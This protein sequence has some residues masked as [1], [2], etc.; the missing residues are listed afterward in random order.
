M[1]AYNAKIRQ[2]LGDGSFVENIK[3]RFTDETIRNQIQ[4]LSLW[5]AEPTVNGQYFASFVPAILDYFPNMESFMFSTNA[6]M[7]G[8]WIYEKFFL[9]LY[10]YC[11]THQR[12]LKWNLQLS[13]DGPPEFN[14]ASRHAGATRNTI[15]AAKILLDNAPEHS[16]FLSIHITTKPTL[17][18]SYMKI[19]NE[20]GLDS[21]NWYFQFFN[22]VQDEVMQHLKQDYVQLQMNGVPTVVDPGCHTVE[23]GKIFA[24]WVNNLKYVDMNK[25]NYYHGQPL[26]YQLIS[27]ID[28]VINNTIIR[29]NPLGSEWNAFSCSAS[30]N[31]ITV[32]Y[33]GD[34]YTCNR[35]CR[36]A[37][38]P[39][40]ERTKHA[41]LSGSTLNQS[42]R[43]WL[44][45]T[46]G[47]AGFHG[48]LKSRRYLFD[49]MVTVMA[50]TGQI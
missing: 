50:K 4:D 19:M 9:P 7:G 17:D 27:G 46:W 43:R 33:N 29:D 42:E 48:D 11:E 34:L 1:E 49:A 21:F 10:E 37:A 18:V 2:A 47:S 35:L 39:E 15:E 44:M 36:N 38:M 3:R 24:E 14:D 8:K 13:L 31:N 26:F 20:R 40:E 32:D 16:E 25:L 5:G 41:M 30:K 22:K 45:N 28:L 12:K 23:D 6:L